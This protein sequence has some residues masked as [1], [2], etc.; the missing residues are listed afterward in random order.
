MNDVY[1]IKPEDFVN[2]IERFS[3]SKLKRKIEVLRIFQL[4]VDNSNQKGFEDLLFSAKYAMGLMR[5]IKNHSGNSEIKNFEDIK[6]DFSSTMEKITL[7]LG[8]LIQKSD[9]DL[10]K[11]FEENF[12]QLNQQGFSNLTDLISD[13]ELTKIYLND[14]KRSQAG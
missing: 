12:F 7:Q 2:E 8:D 9:A 11:H 6:K 13:L 3:K 5:I 14:F 10:K 4:A 1:L